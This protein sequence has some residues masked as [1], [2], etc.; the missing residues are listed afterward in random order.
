MAKFSKRVLSQ[1]VIQLHLNN[2]EVFKGKKQQWLPEVILNLPK[3]KRRISSFYRGCQLQVIGHLNG[4]SVEYNSLVLTYSDFRYR[5]AIS[6]K[7]KLERYR[8]SW[9]QQLTDRA[10]F[11][12]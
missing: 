7:S 4:V 12:L 10:Q 9:V 6:P 11:Y 5:N 2:A 3:S 8:E 1:E